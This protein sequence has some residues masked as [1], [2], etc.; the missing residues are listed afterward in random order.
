MR[1]HLSLPLLLLLV[2]AL[3]QGL[4]P[5]TPFATSAETKAALIRIGGQLT[6]A[7]KAY[8]YD[9]Q[10]SDD[11]GLRLTGSSNYVRAKDLVAHHVL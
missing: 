10:L 2:T 11:I 4:A 3:S 5:Q 8:E 9:R 6:L 1:M 7:A